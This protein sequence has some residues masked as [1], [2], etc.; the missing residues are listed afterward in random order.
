MRHS[1][2]K[3]SQNGVRNTEPEEI[4]AS[5]E[6]KDPLENTSPSIDPFEFSHPISNSVEVNPQQIEVDA[7]TDNKSLWESL[8]NTRQCDEKLLRNSEALI[9]Q[10]L[11]LKEVAVKIPYFPPTMWNVE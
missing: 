4:D 9:K 8:H 2:A 5:I 6:N 11:E 10:M 1:I 3:Q 7:V